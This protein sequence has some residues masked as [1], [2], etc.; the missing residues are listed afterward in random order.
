M[1]AAKTSVWKRPLDEG[2]MDVALYLGGLASMTLLAPAT[3]VTFEAMPNETRGYSSLRWFDSRMREP[4]DGIEDASGPATWDD[5]SVLSGGGVTE[6]GE[7][8]EWDISKT[9]AGGGGL[10]RYNSK[11]SVRRVQ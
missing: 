1:N 7:V 10:V 2:G 9:E 4:V 5:G 3:D 8:S 6:D 11:K